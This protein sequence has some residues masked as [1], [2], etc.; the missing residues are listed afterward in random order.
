MK[1]S[2]NQHSVLVVGCGYVGL[3]TAAC[4][5]DLG[6][7][8]IGIDSSEERIRTLEQGKAPFYEEGLDGL[9]AAGI[10]SGRLEFSSSAKETGANSRIAFVCVPTPSLPEGSADLSMVKEVVTDLA[11][12]LSPDAVIVIKSTV[13]VGTNKLIKEWL[14]RDDLVIASNP[15]FLQAGRAVATFQNPDRIVLGADTEQALDLLSELYDGVDAPIIRTDPQSAE[16]IKYAS[17]A[18]LATRLSFVNTIATLC[19]QGGGDASTVLAG[20]GLDHRIGQ[21]FLQPGPGWGGS[22]FPKDTRALA[23][24]AR[25]Q[26]A[27]TTLLDATLIANEK[28]FDQVV[29]RVSEYFDQDLSRRTVAFWG[30]TFKAGTDD[31]RDSPSLEIAERFIAQ[32]ASVKAYD[33]MVRHAPNREI[34]LVDSALSAVSEADA[35]LVATEWSE[36]IE[37]QAK[38]VIRELRQPAVFDARGIL[39][40]QSYLEAGADFIKVG[41]AT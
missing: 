8:I 5:A 32:G 30:L 27:D 1:T 28:R 26:N 40:E 38:D 6:H 20:M 37:I 2:K 14:D 35:L 19:E 9:V 12:V 3:T 33:P 11:D 21:A 13:P 15:E 17:N 24:V 23:A 41:Y 29:S 10:A 39:N 22:C 25:D 31:L 36:F 7:H 18:Y 4:L 34:E 16:L